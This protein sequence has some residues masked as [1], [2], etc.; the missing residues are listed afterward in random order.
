MRDAPGLGPRQ[1]TKAPDLIRCKSAALA[2]VLVR[3]LPRPTGR[4]LV[5]H[6]ART[7]AATVMIRAAPP[8]QAKGVKQKNTLVFFLQ[9]VGGLHGKPARRV[10]AAPGTRL[11]VLAFGG[12]FTTQAV[13][14]HGWRALRSR[15]TFAG[16]GP[17]MDSRARFHPTQLDA[18]MPC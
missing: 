17:H 8:T 18:C 12:N 6:G 15:C 1:P 3:L 14:A 4:Q 16:D 11:T 13:C 10:A 9:I 2:L 7:S 5:L